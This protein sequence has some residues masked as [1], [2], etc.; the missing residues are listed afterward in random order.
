MKFKI[1]TE[2][3]VIIITEEVNLEDIISW[4]KATVGIQGWSI[5]DYDNDKYY[6]T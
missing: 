1:D 3:K 6:K 4:M 2:E 5:Y